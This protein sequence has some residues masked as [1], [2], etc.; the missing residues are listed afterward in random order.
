MSVAST[1]SPS[2]PIMVGTI[3]PETQATTALRFSPTI[4][5]GIV[6]EAPSAAEAERVFERFLRALRTNLEA[7]GVGWEDVREDRGYVRCTMR[8]E[9]DPRALEMPLVVATDDKTIGAQC[10]EKPAEWVGSLTA[11]MIVFERLSA[12]VQAAVL[13]RIDL[14]REELGSSAQRASQSVRGTTVE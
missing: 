3:M 2:G 5:L 12:S 14:F 6:V 13:R 4:R 10:G 1:D 7:A 9:E 11:D 8:V